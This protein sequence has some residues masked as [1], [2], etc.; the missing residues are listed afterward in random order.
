[1]SAWRQRR[2][3]AV[4]VLAVLASCASVDFE[5]DSEHSGRFTSRAFALTFLGKDYPA[6]P[7]R[8]ARGNAADSALPEMVVK[9]EFIV[10]Y[11]WRL[12]F[13]LDFLSL[14]YAV[15]SGTWGETTPR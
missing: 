10:P 7:L 2:V 6:E 12:D 15:V 3:L 4:L 11:L 1:M 8:L 14:R 13:L 5:P 9:R